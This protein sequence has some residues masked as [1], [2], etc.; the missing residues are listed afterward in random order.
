MPR[1]NGQGGGSTL[2]S[3]GCQ[4]RGMRPGLERGALREQLWFSGTRSQL[5]PKT[6]SSE[7]LRLW[8]GRS[9]EKGL[10]EE[11]LAMVEGKAGATAGPGN[12]PVTLQASA[13]MCREPG[14]VCDPLWASV[15][16]FSLQLQVSESETMVLQ[17][18]WAAP[19]LGG[20]EEGEGARG[21]NR[22][23]DR[24]LETAQTR[25]DVGGAHMCLVL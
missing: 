22:A 8:G 25:R 15:S 3:Q 14:E 11:G 5:S 24:R 13:W 20:R 21:I 12:P 7:K 2:L 4:G 23:L 6:T 1:E 16:W 18:A 9:R 19:A 10:G 17:E